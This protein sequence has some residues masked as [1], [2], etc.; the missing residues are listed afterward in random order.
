MSRPATPQRQ[1]AHHFFSEDPAYLPSRDP[2]SYRP[3]HTFQLPKGAE[4]HYQQQYA[5]MYFLRLAQLRKAVKQKAKEAWDDFE[6]WQQLS[7][8]IIWSIMIWL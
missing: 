1:L 5:D 3:L 8:V 7:R 2:S 4:R 6:V